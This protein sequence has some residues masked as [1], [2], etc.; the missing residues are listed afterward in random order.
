M[1]LHLKSTGVDFT[2]FAGPSAGSQNS[3]LLD[4][5]EEGTWT[6]AIS[7]IS[8]N[9]AYYT[10]YVKTGMNVSVCNYSDL[11]NDGSG[12]YVSVSGFPFA[13]ETHGY[14]NLKLNRSNNICSYLRIN[15]GAATA[16]VFT[17]S[18]KAYGN[19]LNGE[20]FIFSGIYFTGVA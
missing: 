14:A 5:Y 15:A 9:S 7:Y 17:T 12:N 1:A 11:S 19:N 13:T 20:H 10:K 3:E 6:F 16:A 8:V 18:G 2:D 4:D